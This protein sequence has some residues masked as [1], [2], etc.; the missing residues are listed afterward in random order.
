MH[1]GRIVA[2]IDR[3]TQLLYRED[4]RTEEIDDEPIKSGHHKVWS[5]IK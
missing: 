4:T 3:E 2:G 1:E 5:V